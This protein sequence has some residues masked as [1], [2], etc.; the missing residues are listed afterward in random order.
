[1]PVPEIN[2]RI[3]ADGEIDCSL[4]DA[5]G[6]QMVIEAD[7]KLITTLMG[8]SVSDMT[9]YLRVGQLPKGYI[10]MSLADNNNFKIAVLVKSQK[11]PFTYTAGSGAPSITICYPNM[12]FVHTVQEGLISDSHVVVVKDDYEPGGDGLCYRFPFGNVY[13]NSNEICWGHVFSS[14]MEN[15]TP[16]K[17]ED[18]GYQFLLSGYNDHLI[19][20]G[21]NAYDRAKKCKESFSDS[22][23]FPIWEKQDVSQLTVNQ[24]ITDIFNS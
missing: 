10:D 12:I 9:S 2:I 13:S 3:A 16:K 11:L 19:D 20:Q 14:K 21:N 8:K 6:K 15:L 17:C 23:Y 5:L 1:M 4:I 22:L 7:E 24:F 18:V